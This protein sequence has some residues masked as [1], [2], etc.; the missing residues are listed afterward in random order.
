[1]HIFPHLYYL[2]QVISS[3]VLF[4]SAYAALAKIHEDENI[5][6][7]VPEGFVGP[8][9]RSPDS[10]AVIVSYTKPHSTGGEATLLQISVYDFGAKMPPL[11]RERL[12]ERAD[13]YLEQFL[14]GLEKSRECFTAAAP[15]RVVL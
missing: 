7:A 15:F 10:N 2:P 11:P 4:A 13:S 3:M 6:L 5:A 9:S 8:V 1:M 14:Q 12:G